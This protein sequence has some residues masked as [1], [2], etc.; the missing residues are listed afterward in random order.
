M[1]ELF[2]K[3]NFLIVSSQITQRSGLRKLLIDMGVP[4]QSIEVAGNIKQVEERFAKGVVNMIITDDEI[5]STPVADKILDMHFKNNPSNRDR[6][7]LLMINNPTPFLMADFSLKGG[8]AIINKPFKND[9]MVATLTKHL[10]EREKA[11][12]DEMLYYKVA[13]AL[14]S[15]NLDEA[16]QILETFKDKKSF[17]GLFSQAMV[18]E[19]SQNLEK[20]LQQYKFAFEKK[21]DFRLLVKIIKHGVSLK[22]HMDLGPYVEKWIAEFPIHHLSIPDITR[23]IIVNEKFGLLDEIFDCFSRYKITDQFAKI[24]IAAGFVMASVHH[25]KNGEMD[26]AK[27]Y[28]GKGIEYSCNKKEILFKAMEVLVQAGPKTEAEKAYLKFEMT[29]TEVEDKVFEIKM[30][31]L[32][33]PKDKIL[34]ECTKLLTEKVLHPDLFKISIECLKQ[35]GRDPQDMIFQAKQAFPQLNWS[36][37]AKVS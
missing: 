37:L 30:K 15:K 16:N 18:N 20:A 11:T 19:E 34:K 31:D 5:E 13:D 36:D 26:K 7:F 35:M 8:D 12:A 4:Y 32:I 9:T 25:V 33:Y 24:P 22:Q 28:A 14:I 3:W 29:T 10:N 6:F 2:K 17:F 27:I 21:A 23:V 1:K